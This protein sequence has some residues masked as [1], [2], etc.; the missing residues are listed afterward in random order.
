MRVP[1]SVV[2]I[3]EKN[4]ERLSGY[5]LSNPR[6]RRSLPGG[7]RGQG[8]RDV[9]RYSE[10]RLKAIRLLAGYAFASGGPIGYDHKKMEVTAGGTWEIG[11]AA[12][13]RTGGQYPEHRFHRGWDRRHVGQCYKVATHPVKPGRTRS[14]LGFPLEQVMNGQI[15]LLA[16]FF[17]GSLS[18]QQH[19]SRPRLAMFIVITVKH[20][21]F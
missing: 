5:L 21:D 8:H 18:L 7:R 3:C 19:Q 20:A 10:R 14:Y 15:L 13:P 6:C 17:V 16:A 1:L 11:Q 4:I 9:L 12:L 2:Q